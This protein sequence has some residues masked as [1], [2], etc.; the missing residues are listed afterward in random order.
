MHAWSHATHAGKQLTFHNGVG[1]ETSIVRWS[2]L[3]PR[4]WGKRNQ[5]ARHA[6]RTLTDN[7][8][9]KFTGKGAL[10]ASEG[11]T[12]I[13]GP[14]YFLAETWSV[15]DSVAWAVLA[16]GVSR[17]AWAMF[18]EFCFAHRCVGAQVVLGYGKPGARD[19][20]FV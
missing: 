13:G 2:S 20:M 14:I 11:G 3:P 17:E 16:R 15:S 10:Q 4:F 1:G 18:A 6:G 12:A 8:G 7:S 5:A 9:R 19:L